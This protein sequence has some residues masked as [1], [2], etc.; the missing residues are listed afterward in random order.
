MYDADVSDIGFAA[1]GNGRR[2]SAC[3]YTELAHSIQTRF[4]HRAAAQEFV[5]MSYSLEL[6]A[7]LL[8]ETSFP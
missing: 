7:K 5:A 4:V 3:V 8:R 2:L 1:S 6:I